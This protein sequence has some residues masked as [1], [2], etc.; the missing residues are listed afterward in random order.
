MQV[1]Y[2]GEGKTQEAHLKG[3]RKVS[4]RKKSLLN[5]GSLTAV[6]NWEFSSARD[7]VR[8]HVEHASELKN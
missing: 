3:L 4:R 8:N 7:S 1:A 5:K 2:L 6:D